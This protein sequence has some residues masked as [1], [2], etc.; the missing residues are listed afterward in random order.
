MEK[1][2]VCR[3]SHADPRKPLVISISL[4][5]LITVFEFI[6]G[7][8]SGSLALISDTLH[9][10]T[11][12]V[13]LVISFFALRFSKR[14]NTEKSTFGYKR[15]EVLAALLNASALVITSFFLFKEAFIRF[16]HPVD[17][18]TS[19]MIGVAAVCLAANAFSALLLKRDSAHN[20]NIK[21]AYVHLVTDSMSSAAVIAGGILIYL[22]GIKWI[23]PLL[24]FA[25]GLYVLKEGYAIVLQSTHILMMYTPGGLSIA[26]I[27]KEIAKLH[28]VKNVHHVHLWGVTENDIHFEAHIDVSDDMKVSE[29]CKIKNRIEEL[30]KEKY[31]INHSTLQFESEVCEDVSLIR[32]SKNGQSGGSR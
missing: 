24:T 5:L 30:L 7:I 27:A 14:A 6:G 10:M 28:G 17:V 16:I 18:N 11:D 2:H 21:S 32:Q 9:N 25:I 1:I 3:H 4:N 13:A 29:T 8:I 12:T 26:E 20:I 19:I 31:A 23:D 22:S 15:A